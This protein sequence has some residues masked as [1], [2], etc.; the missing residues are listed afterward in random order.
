MSTHEEAFLT[1]EAPRYAAEVVAHR[2]GI[3]ALSPLPGPSAPAR[4]AAALA[5]LLS[6]LFILLF[7]LA[8][9]P[10]IET[11]PGVVM[12]YDGHADVAAPMA[13]RLHLLVHD[14]QRVRRGDVLAEISVDGTQSVDGAA[15]V[16]AS[17]QRSATQLLEKRNAED[18]QFQTR[19]NRLRR[20][21]H[22][23]DQEL[24]ALV[25][26]TRIQLERTRM[27]ESRAQTIEPLTRE[28]FVTQ[29][30]YLSARD[31]AR[32]FAL[33]VVDR[34]KAEAA[35]RSK[36][37][38]RRFEIEEVERERSVRQ[39][40]AD[41]QISRLQGELAAARDARFQRIVA[42]RSGVVTALSSADGD[43]VEVNSRILS[44][45]GGIHGGDIE[46]YVAAPTRSQ[47]RVGSNALIAVR[48]SNGQ[49]S[50]LEARVSELG[51]AELRQP[52]GNWTPRGVASVFR[53]RLAPNAREGNEVLWPG[54]SINARFVLADRTLLQR[55]TGHDL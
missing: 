39:A 17:L 45:S 42:T 3:A 50:W 1:A 32:A 28:R 55:I 51:S 53:V 19:L 33:D 11:A 14:Q 12:A 46:A 24:N 40:D 35:T 18:A 27:A 20:L 25:E 38:Q 36:M 6:V 47:L 49:Q 54:Q 15:T 8:P 48:Q 37:E 22:I 21:Q 4:R 43:H 44:I 41:V 16:L 23:D 13:G 7:C 5:M 30:E 9:L 10:V 2:H 34:R 29:T 26:A 31:Q 52:S